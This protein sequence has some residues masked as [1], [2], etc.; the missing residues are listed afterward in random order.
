MV[1][2]DENDRLSLPDDLDDRLGKLFVDR[3]IHLPVR[4]KKQGTCKRVMAK[5]PQRLVGQAVI[6]AFAFS[7]R[8]VDS[9]CS[10]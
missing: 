8:Q 9:R 3:A 2:L 4:L 1:V 10:V 6:I 7:F 5:W